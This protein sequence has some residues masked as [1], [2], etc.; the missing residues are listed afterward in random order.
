MID[1]LS[2]LDNPDTAKDLEIPDDFPTQVEL[3][4]NAEYLGLDDLKIKV[5]SEAIMK[6][7][8]F[9]KY[10][11]VRRHYLDNLSEESLEYVLECMTPL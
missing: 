3:F 11:N 4:E 2:Y 7:P 8:E 5:V 1:Y 6:R 9:V 10:T